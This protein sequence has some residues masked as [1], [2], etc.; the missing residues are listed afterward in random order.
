MAF[1]LNPPLSVV[2]HSLIKFIIAASL[3]WSGLVGL[4]TL[5]VFVVIHTSSYRLVD[6]GDTTTVVPLLLLLL[7]LGT[8]SADD[9]DDDLLREGVVVAVDG[10]TEAGERGCCCLE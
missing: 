4:V 10:G 3:L 7:P 9:D 5:L 1:K 6:S 2:C 8:V